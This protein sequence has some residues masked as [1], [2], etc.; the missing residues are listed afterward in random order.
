MATSPA[1][2]TW[3]GTDINRLAVHRII[4]GYAACSPKL[5]AMFSGD[6]GEVTCKRC[7][8]LAAA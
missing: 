7:L 2:K 4:D 8:T 3:N 6:N 5:V 1:V